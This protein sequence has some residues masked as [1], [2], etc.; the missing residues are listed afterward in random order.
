MTL[1][2]EQS[3]TFPQD[4]TATPSVVSAKPERSYI[5]TLDG[6]RAIAIGLVLGAHSQPMLNHNG[7]KLAHIVATFF[8][9]TGYGVDVFFCLSGYLICTLLLREKQRSG[10]I[11]LG[12]FYTRRAFRILPPMLVYVAFISILAAQRYVPAISFREIA[13]VLFFF[14]NYIDGSWY[15]GHFWSLAVEE[16]FYSFIPLL[17]LTFSRRWAVRCFCLLIVLC[18]A[19]R[20]FEFSQGWSAVALIQFHTENRI[21]GLLWGALLAVGLHNAPVRG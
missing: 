17:L 13:G 2:L 9:H 6:W 14:R 8:K 12:R 11:S 4:G 21:D 10:S 7:S 18:I 5:P 3:S 15:T 16:H 1:K 20:W 19:I